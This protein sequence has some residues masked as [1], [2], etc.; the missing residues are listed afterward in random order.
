MSLIIFDPI[1]LSYLRRQSFILEIKILFQ[2]VLNEV[3]ALSLIHFKPKH[4]EHPAQFYSVC[5][6]FLYSFETF[7]IHGD[8]CFPFST[9][10]FQ[11]WPPP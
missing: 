11:I 8:T 9:P 3:T 4:T 6:Y 7:H 5:S 2:I 10:L 1:T